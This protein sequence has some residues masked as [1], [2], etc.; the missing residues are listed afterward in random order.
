MMVGR[1]RKQ[2]SGWDGVGCP[3]DLP[4]LEVPPHIGIIEA[5]PYRQHTEQG[6]KAGQHYRKREDPSQNT[7]T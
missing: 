1:V 2:I 7:G 4:S 6:Q 5:R 3:N